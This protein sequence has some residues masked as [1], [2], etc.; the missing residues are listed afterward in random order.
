LERIASSKGSIGRQDKRY[1]NH[2]QLYRFRECGKPIK[3]IN[4]YLFYVLDEAKDRGLSFDEKKILRD[5]LD[6]GLKI[7]VSQGQLDYELK[8]LKH[9]LKKRSLEYYRRI[10]GIDKGKPNPM[11]VPRPGNVEAWEK[12]KELD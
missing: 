12:V 3:A 7:A 1:V 9:K 4:T 11:F 2:P 5:Y 6:A 8:L 10:E